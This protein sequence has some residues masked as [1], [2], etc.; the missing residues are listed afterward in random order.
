[1]RHSEHTSGSQKNYWKVHTIF[2]TGKR[3]H[4]VENFS[5][6]RVAKLLNI[7]SSALAGR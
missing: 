5:K 6:Y 2:F 3:E 1:M 7:F 4:L